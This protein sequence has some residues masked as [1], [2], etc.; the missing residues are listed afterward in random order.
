MFTQL[1][2]THAWELAYIGS[3]RL[4]VTFAA[5]VTDKY[6]PDGVTSPHT[7]SAPDYTLIPRL[8]RQVED[9]ADRF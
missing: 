5:S 8:Y 4:S 1:G 3:Y 9:D 2:F 7:L 6:L